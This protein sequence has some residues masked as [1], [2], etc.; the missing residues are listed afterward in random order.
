[1]NFLRNIFNWLNKKNKSIKSIGRYTN[2]NKRF[3]AY[4]LNEWLHREDGPAYTL[5]REDGSISYEEYRL[6]GK[7]HREDGPAVIDYCTNNQIRHKDY[8]LNGKE[9]TKEQTQEFMFNKAFDEQVNE[10]LSG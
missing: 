5:Y 4:Y 9:V 2:G 6:N 7:L 3:E 8:Y 1:M 10:V